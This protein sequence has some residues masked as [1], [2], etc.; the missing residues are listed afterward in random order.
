MYQV[1]ARFNWQLEFYLQASISTNSTFKFTGRPIYCVLNKNSTSDDMV[2]VQNIVSINFSA[3]VFQMF[4]N[5]INHAYQNLQ[6]SNS[7]P[8]CHTSITCKKC[9][10]GTNHIQ[11][12]KP[13]GING[14]HWVGI[15]SIKLQ[16]IHF[17]LIGCN[18]NDGLGLSFRRWLSYI[19]IET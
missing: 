14:T 5:F 15:R 16:R 4:K 9:T 8:S 2:P 13:N 19:H 7:R 10:R 17:K 6:G 3:L 1:K 12:F 18:R 11:H